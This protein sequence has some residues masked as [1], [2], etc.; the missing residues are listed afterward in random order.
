M[1]GIGEDA[2]LLEDTRLIYQPVLR[3]VSILQDIVCWNPR[4]GGFLAISE[5]DCGRLNNFSAQAWHIA[6]LLSAGR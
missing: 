5:M 2:L 3:L 1:G 6:S 4:R